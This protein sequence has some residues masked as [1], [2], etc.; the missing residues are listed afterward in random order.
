MLKDLIRKL[1]NKKGESLTETLVALL[2]SVLSLTLL[3]SMILSG[4][5]IT[6]RSKERMTDYYDSSS[7]IVQGSGAS[8]DGSITIK[9]AAGKYCRLSPDEN[10]VRVNIYVNYEFKDTP[11]VF[12]R[13]K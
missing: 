3:A 12:Y 13:S 2:I 1:K 4:N 9:D 10:S 11:V 6:S 8:I 7:A 5:R